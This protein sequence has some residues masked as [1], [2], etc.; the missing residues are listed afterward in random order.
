M[1]DDPR[2]LINGYF[3]GMLSEEQ[4]GTLNA[5]I[6]QDPEHAKRFAREALLHDRLRNKFRAGAELRDDKSRA[7]PF[8]PRVLSRWKSVAFLASAA[9]VILVLFAMMHGFHGDSA[10]AADAELQRLIQVADRVGDRT[11]RITAL[12]DGDGEISREVDNQKKGQP[13]PPIDGAILF[14]RGP[15]QFVLVR[16]F[17]DGSEFITGSDGKTS[18]ACPPP[19]PGK[20]GN[21]H[22]SADP[23]RFR[24][25]VPGHQHSIPFLDI[26][27]SLDQLRAVYDLTLLP[28][29]PV[30]E[31]EIWNGIRAERREKGMGGPKSVEIWYVPQTGVIQQMC[32]AGLP[33][34]RGGPRSLL[35]ELIDQRD[36]GPGFFDHPAHHGP[37]R[38]ILGADD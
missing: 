1:T 10:K 8:P 20:K 16:K 11:Y 28:T 30:K 32:F 23:W 27:T 25:K 15:D 12:D 17:E 26:R 18:W 5:W 36:L 19:K 21:V 22:V 33:R 34:E 13:Q 29:K 14:T 6:A 4:L 2:M 9:A 38:R 3:D 31:G 24:G 37:E 7:E 35:V